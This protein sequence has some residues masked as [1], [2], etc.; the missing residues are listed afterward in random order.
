MKN[1]NRNW[2]KGY[3]PYPID[4]KGT[5]DV[6]TGKITISTTISQEFHRLAKEHNIKWSEAMRVGLS[7]I[8]ADLG[9]KDYDTSLN[10]YRKMRFFQDKVEEYG[11]K[12]AELEEKQEKLKGN[13]NI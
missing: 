3:T 4:D 13:L 7:I 5:L 10:I 1:Y 12:I 6:V 2:E 11:N 9:I 8:F